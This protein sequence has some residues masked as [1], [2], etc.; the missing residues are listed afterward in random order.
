MKS[1]GMLLSN[2]REIYCNRNHI[3]CLKFTKLLQERINYRLLTDIS[4][5]S[6]FSKYE[7][8]KRQICNNKLTTHTCI[9]FNVSDANVLF[10]FSRISHLTMDKIIKKLYVQRYFLIHN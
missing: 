3:F 5:I 9:L 2:I 4:L 6:K 7:A 8:K 10:F 1:M